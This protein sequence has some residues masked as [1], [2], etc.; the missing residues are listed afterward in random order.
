MN[1]T[2]ALF[3]LSYEEN[4]EN[5]RRKRQEELEEIYSME[6]KYV[7]ILTY[8]FDTSIFVESFESMEEA[9]ERLKAVLDEELDT[10]KRECEYEPTVIIQDSHDLELIYATKEQ[11]DE[12]INAGRGKQRVF[13]AARYFIVEI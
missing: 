11:W 7:F 12:A 10:V 5:Q 8:N 9:E 4:L 3:I 2:D 1:M 13:D 6:K